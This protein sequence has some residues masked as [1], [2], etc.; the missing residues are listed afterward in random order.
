M[1][2]SNITWLVELGPSLCRISIKGQP[3][4][5]KSEFAGFYGGE[6]VKIRIAA[7][8]NDGAANR[9]LIE[10]LAKNFS[11]PKSHVVLLKGETSRHK[12]VEIKTSAANIR[13]AFAPQEIFSF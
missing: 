12:V 11:L 3:N 5:S 1:N 8:A 10:F 2:S 13:K 4:A 6:A 7:P 9:E